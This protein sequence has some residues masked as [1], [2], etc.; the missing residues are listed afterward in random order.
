MASP[1]S[2]LIMVERVTDWVAKRHAAYF[3]SRG[4]SID[5]A[6]AELWSH[7][8]T[9]FCEVERGELAPLLL[10]PL[11][12][13]CAGRRALYLS[14]VGER[15][16]ARHFVVVIGADGAVERAL[17]GSDCCRLG[18]LCCVAHPGV[19]DE[20]LRPRTPTDEA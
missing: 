14:H 12:P 8:G 13:L 10:A 19:A 9:F 11:A 20:L 5:E 3:R 18:R 7:V 16:A 1:A 15:P 6:Q 2:Q 17:S 4:R